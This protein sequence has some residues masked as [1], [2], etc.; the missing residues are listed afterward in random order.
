[1]GIEY[2]KEIDDP[3]LIQTAFVTATEKSGL[4]SAHDPQGQAGLGSLRKT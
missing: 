1:M 2:V 3:I 4:L